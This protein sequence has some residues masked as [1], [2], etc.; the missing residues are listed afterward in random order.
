VIGTGI[1]IRWGTCKLIPAKYIHCKD[2]LTTKLAS[3]V[4]MQQVLGMG[5]AELDTKLV[6]AVEDDCFFGLVHKNTFGMG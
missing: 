3:A 4:V 5:T 6:T 1:V 2:I